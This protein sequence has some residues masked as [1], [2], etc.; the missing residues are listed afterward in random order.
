MFRKYFLPYLVWWFYR[1]LSGS[2]KKSV[3]E[4]PLVTKARKNHQPVILAHWHGDE[5]ALLPLVKHYQ[6]ATMTSTSLVVPHQK[7]LQ[8]EEE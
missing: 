3:V 7:V 4:H 5:L 2:W 1:L 6:L 8:Q